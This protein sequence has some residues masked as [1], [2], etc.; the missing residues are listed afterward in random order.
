MVIKNIYTL[1]L[2][3]I[4][5]KSCL[6]SF[7]LL[8]LNAIC[9]IVLSTLLTKPSF[10]QQIESYEKLVAGAE[11]VKFL[12]ASDNGKWIGYYSI[13]DGFK[14]KMVL[15]NIANPKLEI[16]R[17]NIYSGI[18]VKNKVA[19][20]TGN[21]IEYLDPEMDKSIFIDDVKRVVYDDKSD[22]FCI[23]YDQKKNNKLELY[24]P[25]RKLIETIDDVYFFYFKDKDLIVRKKN[26]LQNEVLSFKNNTLRKIFSTEDDI[27]TVLPSGLKQGGYIIATRSAGRSSI[28]YLS[29]ELKLQKLEGDEFKDFQE[30][31][32]SVSRE[33][34]FLI[35]DLVKSIPKPSGLVDVW[36]GK[37]FDLGKNV[38]ATRVSTLIAWNPKDSQHFILSQPGYFGSTSIGNYLYLMYAV[39][40]NQVDMMDKAGT[41]AG[42]DQLFLWNSLTNKYV[43][44]SDV[45]R[46]IVISPDGRYV[47]IKM[48][49]NWKLYNTSTLKFEDIV[50]ADE[51][52][53]Y[54]SSEK[55][56]LWVGG[57]RIVGQNLENKEMQVVFRHI[58][59]DIE[60]LNFDRINT[61]LGSRRD[62]RSVNIKK[63]LVLK[64]TDK[65]SK[66]IS[67]AYLKNGKVN[68]IVPWTS[69]YVTEFAKMKNLD[70]FYWIA[71]NYNKR[72]EVVVKKQTEEPKVFY[73]SSESSKLFEKAEVKKMHYKGVNR[74]DVMGTL[75]MPLNYDR[76]KKY[77][78]I[79]HIYEQ[80]EYLTNRFLKPTFEYQTGLN[81][82]LFIE[83]GFAVLLPDITYGD[84]GAGLSALECVD[85]ALDELQKFDNIDMSRIGLMGQS[86]GGYETNFIATH[87]KR[88]AAYVSGA[89]VSDVIRTY[90]AFNHHFK[91]PDYYRYE[92]RQYY[93]KSTV[94]ENPQKY[95]KNNPIMFV[96]NV[97]APMLLWT[98]K[99]DGNV[100]PEGSMSMFI[101]LRKYKKPVVAL[102]YDKEGHT[103]RKPAGQKDLSMRIL[104][105]WNYFLKD[106]KNIPWIDQQM[107]D[108]L[109]LD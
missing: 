102:F 85:K 93:F 17:A 47:L 35:L 42:I 54:F 67:Y 103:I 36:Y 68:T 69:D 13:A 66:Q 75:Y 5:F 20:Q 38:R 92:G 77:P 53:P 11:D 22:L 108:T 84:K 52:M 50:M 23:H 8:H 64:I 104:D 10:G 56:V 106:K 58:D 95:L 40:N 101:G 73:V 24:T 94:A 81:I 99:D 100:S 14:K 78:V 83:Q 57:S 109:K 44:V 107:I 51:M 43:F 46:E 21:K 25:D 62:F 2:R 86:F 37:D 63:S 74:E 76:S 70:D 34:N 71:E 48:E 33:D 80:Q 16:T 88:F 72:P 96:Q 45:Q 97:S 18:F 87:S 12:F 98:G 7:S 27:I 9:I 105:W 55:G 1:W 65:K 60:L 89:A 79:V 59:S 90:Y 41:P 32:L 6:T 29:N 61:V 91:S 31:S 19:I 3:F 4:S 39:D 15:Q 49:K 30:I 26:H 28:H 82:P